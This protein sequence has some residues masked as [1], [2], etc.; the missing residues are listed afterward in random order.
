MILWLHLAG[1]EIARIIGGVGRPSP[2]VSS[3]APPLY[4]EVSSGDI[5]LIFIKRSHQY[6]MRIR[7]G[8]GEQSVGDWS[9]AALMLTIRRVRA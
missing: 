2:E 1:G 5:D 8:G 3:G 9:T 6:L 4:P 7:L